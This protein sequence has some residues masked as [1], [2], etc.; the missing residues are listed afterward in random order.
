MVVGIERFREH[1]RGFDRAFVLIGGAA[2]EAWMSS[3]A[4]TFRRTKDLDIVLVVEALDAAFAARFRE[5]VEAGRYEVRQR[6]D[7]GRREFYRFLKPKET[8]FPFM[9]E[10]FSRAPAGIELFPGQTITPVP[11]DE[12]VASLSAILME[13]GYYELVLASRYDADGIPMISATGLI[14][15]KAR[16]WLDM[17]RRQAEGGAV[18]D[19]DLKK[20]RNDVFRLALTLPG[21]PGPAVAEAIRADLRK[22][23]ESFPAG[24]EDW[25]A[26]VQALKGSVSK[27]PAAAELVRTIQTFF[28]LV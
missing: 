24:A 5:F 21:N 6:A 26:I 15:L 16:A 12:T 11:V 23:L 18:D 27:L 2:C 9:L 8:G 7:T 20:H 14:P 19:G 10:L 3:N 1:F 25:T 4:L 17:R 22:F 28:G 13:E